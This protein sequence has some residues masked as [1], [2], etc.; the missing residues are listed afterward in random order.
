MFAGNTRWMTGEGQ[1]SGM[2]LHRLH[3]RLADPLLNKAHAKSNPPGS[4]HPPSPLTRGQGTCGHWTWNRWSSAHFQGCQEP[5]PLGNCFEWS[6]DV[7]API[8][9][10]FGGAEGPLHWSLRGFIWFMQ[11]GRCPPPTP[12]A[13][14]CSTKPSVWIRAS[15]DRN[16]P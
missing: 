8:H 16:H 6:L 12:T 11:G 4:S 10:Q 2:C 9:E 5:P 3:F 15:W 14:P 7:L 1:T 13:L